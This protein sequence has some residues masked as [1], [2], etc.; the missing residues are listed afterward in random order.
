MKLKELNERIEDALS[1]KKYLEAFVLKSLYVEGVITA[2]ST[3]I[4][5]SKRGYDGWVNNVA[6]AVVS[7]PEAKKFFD[8][9][10]NLQLYKKIKE[11][12]ESGLISDTKQIEYLNTWRDKYRNEIF[13]NFAELSLHEGEP[14]KKSQEGYDFMKRFT[15]QEW[16]LRL[17]DAFR[18]TESNLP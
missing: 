11:L 2:L 8:E 1:S 5:A 4:L 15:T 16:F 18:K 3:A 12:R 10:V 7:D 9:A 6:E 17:E 14:D 13:H